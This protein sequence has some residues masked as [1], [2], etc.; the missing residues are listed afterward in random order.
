MTNYAERLSDRGYGAEAEEI[1]QKVLNKMPS[2]DSRR[3]RVLRAYARM[4]LYRTSGKD[5]ADIHKAVE[6]LREA[7]RSNPSDAPNRFY[8][9]LAYSWLS[10]HESEATQ[11][12]K[13]ALLLRPEFEAAG[14]LLLELEEDGTTT[15][16]GSS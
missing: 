16:F 10:G 11:H 1:F 5:E 8:L 3:D 14:E 15:R 7:A 6:L 9:G 12:V 13:E 4:P 2:K